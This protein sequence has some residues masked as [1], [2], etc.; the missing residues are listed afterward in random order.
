MQART[1]A[2]RWENGVLDSTL[3]SLSVLELDG[4]VDGNLNS[5]F[6][7]DSLMM[8]AS[9][10]MLTGLMAGHQVRGQ[11]PSSLILSISFLKM[12]LLW[13]SL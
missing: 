2:L 8:E 12:T 6:L 3:V 1:I 11:M 9:L 13:R 4:V 10:E 7:K 5:I